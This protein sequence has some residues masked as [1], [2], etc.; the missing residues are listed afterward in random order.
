MTIDNTAPL[1]EPQ[2]DGEDASNGHHVGASRVPAATTEDS[3]WDAPE[4]DGDDTWSLVAE[5][6]EIDHE[7]ETLLVTATSGDEMTIVLDPDLVDAVADYS[8]P[9]PRSRDARDDYDDEE[10]ED[11]EEEYRTSGVSRLSGWSAMSEWWDL[12]PA[13]RRKWIT[14][15]MVALVLLILLVQAVR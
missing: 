4:D 6:W 2:Q 9:R 13:E 7:T 14:I 11:E 15:G 10:Y 1:E 8:R 12:I 3:H 5:S